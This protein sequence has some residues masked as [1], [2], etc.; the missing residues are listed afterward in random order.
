MLEKEA[1]ATTGTTA[2]VLIPGGNPQPVHAGKD[3]FFLQIVA[4]QA[5]FSGSIWSDTSRL[6]IT[7]QVNLNHP[8]LGNQEVM[9]IQRSREVHRDRVEK[10]GLSPNLV[11]LVPATMT[12]VTV[13]ID[14]I[15]D[16]KSRLVALAG[17]I[18]EDSFLSALSLAPGAAVA[19]KTIGGLAQKVITTFMPADERQPILQFRGDFNIGE[20]NFREGHYAILGSRDSSRP[21]PNPMPALSLVNEEL[22]GDSQPLNL[23]YVVLKVG[24]TEARGRERND[25]ALWGEK[26][27]LAED[28]AEHVARDRSLSKEQKAAEWNNCKK[29]FIEAR[30][31]LLADSNYTGDEADSIYWSSWDKCENALLGNDAATRSG[32]DEAV[33]GWTPDLANDRSWLE[34]PP[35][36]EL[37]TRLGA[38]ARQLYAARKSLKSANLD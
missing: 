20:S 6:L 28:L 29:A 5:V 37:Q 1:L 3:Y 32:A 9:A 30:A 10:L 2:P 26:L 34:I 14:F 11:S 27:K 23:S 13:S 19:A 31:L 17:L 4:A 35:P 7:S 24:R 18:N 25:N 12:H 22:L 16:K 38:Y 15:L 21:L 8:A 33:P 36:K